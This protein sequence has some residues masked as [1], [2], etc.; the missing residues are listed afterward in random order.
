MSATLTI[1]LSDDLK[2]FVEERAR[3]GNFASPAE[4][5]G[6]L[7]RDEQ[8]RTEQQRLEQMLLDGLDSGDPIRVTDAYWDDLAA[9]A[10][11]RADARTNGDRS[12]P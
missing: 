7:V 9:R 8:K 12:R 3:A 11:Q 10:R 5:I 1:S 4:F 2:A 6:H